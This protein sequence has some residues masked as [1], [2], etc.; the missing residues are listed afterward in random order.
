MQFFIILDDGNQWNKIVH[1]I[2]VPFICAWSS[3]NVWQFFIKRRK[4]ANIIP[5][6]ISLDIGF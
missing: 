5:T 3:F 4:E 2:M 1:G 6:R